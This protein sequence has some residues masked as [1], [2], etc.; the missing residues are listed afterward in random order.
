MNQTTGETVER[1]MAITLK[2]GPQSQIFQ[3]MKRQF[4][5]MYDRDIF[6]KLSVDEFAILVT[7]YIAHMAIVFSEKDKRGIV[8]LQ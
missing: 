6:Q 1:C 8:T 3:K 7:L 4:D 2:A 5:A